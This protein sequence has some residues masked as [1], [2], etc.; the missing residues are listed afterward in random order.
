MKRSAL[1][2]AVGI[3]AMALL[4]T[5]AMAQVVTTEATLQVGVTGTTNGS[6]SPRGDER[7]D[8]V[9][10]IQPGLNIRRQ[11]KQVSLMADFGLDMM[12]YA[13]GTQRDRA[14][15]RGRAEIN[16][17]VVDRIF[18][19]NASVDVRQVELDPYASRA[20]LGSSSNLRASETYR[21]APAFT[22]DFTPRLGFAAHT[23][24]SLTRQHVDGVSDLRSTQTTLR[25]EQKPAPVGAALEVSRQD[26]H[27][28]SAS[29]DNLMVESVRASAS[30]QFL[31]DWTAS[32]SAGR[33]RSEFALGRRTEPL[34]GLGLQWMPSP[35][36]TLRANIDDRFFGRGWDIGFQHRTPSLSMTFSLS[37]EPVTSS[38][39]LGRVEAGTDL[40]AFLDAILTTRYPDPAERGALVDKF[41]NSRGLPKVVPGA[42]SVFADYAQLQTEGNAALVWVS[43][44]N[45]LTLSAYQRTLRRLT[46][47]G[48][49]TAL[50]VGVESDSRQ[51]GGGINLNRR[52][53]P[54]LA[55]YLG[56]QWSRI[57]GLS[58]REGDS[59]RETRYRLGFVHNLSAFTV[60]SY[61]LEHTRFAT[62]VTTLNSYVVNSGFLG[63]NHRF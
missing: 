25:L 49:D 51:Q 5:W 41:L 3:A 8:L 21:V 58:D 34:Y 38:A 36:T 28:T 24:Q 47:A 59:T 15:P 26:T 19:V 2:L 60:A 17:T 55:I 62:T 11:G 48:D 39:T 54:Q 13:K 6:L 46:R 29:E 30:V 61:G 27:Y 45:T 22:Y 7:A 10:T 63:L 16:A 56:A 12:S 1:R 9:T 33:E 14:S 40:S 57:V 18:V 35:R 20:Q 4:P 37:R 50:Q 42:G 32:A 44:R 31:D 52:M 43:Q 53:T 23:E